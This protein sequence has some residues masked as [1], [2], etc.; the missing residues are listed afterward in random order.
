VSDLE[1]K[2]IAITRDGRTILRGLNASFLA[3]QLTAVIGP[4]GAGKSTLLSVAAGLL[5]PDSG[6]VTLGGRPLTAIG[7]QGLARRRAYLPQN[8]RVDWPISVERVIALGLTPQLPVFG[9][10]TLDLRERVD[11]ALAEHDLLGLRDQAADTLSGGELSRTML[12]RATVADP[13]ILI[14]DEPTAG[15][16]PRHAIEAVRALR[17]H[18]DAGKTVVMAIHELDLA[19]RVADQVLAI[20]MGEVLASG[21]RE[22]VLN[23]E[24]LTQLFDT[25]TRVVQDRD[26][27][28]IRFQ[29]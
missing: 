25:P 20:R 27:L 9:G 28:T 18:A 15:L 26:G 29:G 10:L 17:R 23:E 4:N 7:R 13:E 8:P 5:T 3:G 2:D 16:D 11:Q 24:T 22:T 19:A 12:A 6:A 21:P 14:V 1:L